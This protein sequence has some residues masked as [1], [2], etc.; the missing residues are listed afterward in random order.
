MHELSIVLSIVETAEAIVKREAATRVDAIELEIGAIA[1]IEL[2]ALEFAWSPA[3]TNT[4]LEHAQRVIHN[5]PA[6][7][8]CSNCGHEYQAA[9][10]FVPCPVCNEVLNIVLRGKELAIKT[11]T[12]S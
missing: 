1:G 12:V 9:E 7:L 11:L 3:V 10:R 4:V 5:I 2:T 8:R 6:L